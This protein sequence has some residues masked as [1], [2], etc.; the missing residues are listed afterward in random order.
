MISNKTKFD[1]TLGVNPR[2]RNPE[3]TDETSQGHATEGTIV[4][5]FREEGGGEQ[6][7][8]GQTN[9]RE[10]ERPAAI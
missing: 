7:V 4:I 5:Y 6:P 1:K 8:H 10:G 3:S 9:H 2:G